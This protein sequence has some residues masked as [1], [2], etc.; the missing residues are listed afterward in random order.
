M[1]DIKEWKLYEAGKRFNDELDPPYFKTA[2]TNSE[3]FNG[4]QWKNLKAN[5]MPTP[6]FNIVKRCITHFVSVLTSSK[7]KI[8]FLPAFDG[9]YEPTE[10]EML[11]AI[12]TGQPPL[13]INESI[14]ATDEVQILLDKFKFDNKIRD[15]LF[16]AAI[17]GDGAAHFF[18]DI[19]K[20]PYKG[21]GN[22]EVAIEGDI[23][24]EL[25][26]GSN[27]YFGNSNNPNVSTSIQPWIIV[28]GRD[29]VDNLKEE[30]LRYMQEADE[31]KAS[32][33]NGIQEDKNNEDMTGNKAEINISG[34]K[35][36]KAT[37]IICYKYSK[38][39]RTIHVSKCTEKV[40]IYEDIDTGMTEYPIAWLNW[41]KQKNNY[42]G[43]AV[44]TS[45]IPNQIFIN[46]M[47]AMVM[48][49]LM[50]SAFPKAVYDADK[51]PQWTNEIGGA[52]AVNNISP[53]ENIRGLAG[54]LEPGNMSNQI[55]GVLEMAIQYTKETLG[56]NDAMTGDI[57]PENASGRSIVTTIKQSMIPLEN[58]KSNLYDFLE[59][60][61]KILVNLM[62]AYYGARPV[63]V[64][65]AEG[66]QRIDYDFSNLN[67]TYFSTKVEVG[68]SSYWS[69]IA[70]METLDNLYQRDAISVIEYLETIP[71]GYI[72]NK[73]ELIE[74]IKNR[75][76]QMEQD[77]VP[78]IPGSGAGTSGGSNPVLSTN[79]GS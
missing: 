56:I 77:G 29:N 73:D 45:I 63:S 49:H 48:Y 58:I 4:N 36:G 10:E 66:N 23:E 59:D 41:E 43:R 16:N 70:S 27:I 37:Y 6:V 17:M 33:I 64:K 8:Q 76:M 9:Q 20:R 30:A 68:P 78:P 47:F 13:V 22:G 2:E 53:G 67:D 52:I 26:D 24:C 75:L 50:M 34:D 79:Q 3:F 5:G 1:S 44:C 18:F 7:L 15:L 61:G 72:Q 60:V 25:V 14:I 65:S 38:E 51:I 71:N 57:N 55:T 21:N 69:E 32:D 31:E 28:S 19:N 46:R 12:M 40:Y 42:H 11:Q 35:N 39:T 74:K 54:Y 62:S